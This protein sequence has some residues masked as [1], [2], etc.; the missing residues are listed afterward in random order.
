MTFYNEKDQ[1]YLERNALGIS[2]GGI[3]LQVRDGM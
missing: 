3:L 1:L 2:P